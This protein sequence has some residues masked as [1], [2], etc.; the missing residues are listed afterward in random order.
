M[1]K[2]SVGSN[3]ENLEGSLN[4][5]NTVYT[6]TDFGTKLL[7][8]M[9]KLEYIYQHF[10]DSEKVH[11]IDPHIPIENTDNTLYPCINN[12][13]EYGLFEDIIDSYYLDSQ[14]RDGFTCNKTCYAH[15]D[16]NNILVS[17]QLNSLADT[18]QQ[19][20][21]YTNEVDSSLFTSD[22]STPCKF[23]IVPDITETETEYQ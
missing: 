8:E 1:E 11:E 5:E 4:S 21:V 16:N 7:E 18:A 6:H 15:Y 14:I 9:E 13:I 19:H 20:Q 22:T 2:M 3:N 17:Q 23:N 12:N 10:Q